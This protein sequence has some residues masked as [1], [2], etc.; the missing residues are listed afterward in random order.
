MSAFVL[1]DL[2][3]SLQTSDRLRGRSD[4]V[5]SIVGCPKSRRWK[6]PTLV[7]CTL[8]DWHITLSSEVVVSISFKG[9]I[10]YQLGMLRHY[11]RQPEGFR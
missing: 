8:S 4:R 2:S 9:K 5:Y 7:A 1:V 3:V 6:R 10:C 11:L